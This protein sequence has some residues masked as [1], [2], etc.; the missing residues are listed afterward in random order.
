MVASVKSVLKNKEFAGDKVQEWL[1]AIFEDVL[2]HLSVLGPRFKYC[3]TGNI[4]QNCGAGLY[5]A[6]ANRYEKNTDSMFLFL[7]PDFAYTKYQEGSILCTLVV[8]GFR[9]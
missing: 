6:N 7:T 3:A 8:Y 4:T 5:I 2:R 9:I 1:A